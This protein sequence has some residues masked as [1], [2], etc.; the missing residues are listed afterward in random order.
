MNDLDLVYGMA[1]TTTSKHS[2][3]LSGTGNSSSASSSG[4]HQEHGDALYHDSSFS[5]SELK[6]IYIQCVNLS[7]SNYSRHFTFDKLICFDK[8]VITSW[9]E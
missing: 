2:N 9:I 5:A 4:E 1:S 7:H 3:I 6:E 8:T